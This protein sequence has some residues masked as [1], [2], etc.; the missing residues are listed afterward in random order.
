METINYDLS[1]DE[2]FKDLFDMSIHQG[3]IIS[4]DY[5]NN[6]AEVDIDDIGVKSEVPIFYHCQD[7]TTTAGATAFGVD[8]RVWVINQEGGCE[9]NVSNLKIVGFVDGLKECLQTFILVECGAYVFLFGETNYFYP[10]SLPEISYPCL[11][12][13]IQEFLDTQDLAVTTSLYTGVSAGEHPSFDPTLDC[14]YGD[15]PYDPDPDPSYLSANTGCGDFWNTIECLGHPAYHRI[16]PARRD[17]PA[18]GLAY[19]FPGSWNYSL[20]DFPGQ[21][22][23]YRTRVDYERSETLPSPP[24]PEFAS[25]IHERRTWYTPI[26]TMGYQVGGYGLGYFIEW[27]GADRW[28]GYTASDSPGDLAGPRTQNFYIRTARSMIQIYYVQWIQTKHVGHL[29]YKFRR[30]WHILAALN[31]YEDASIIDP[32]NQTESDAFKAAINNLRDY[33]MTINELANDGAWSPGEYDS[34]NVLTEAPEYDTTPDMVFTMY[35]Y[36]EE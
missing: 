36:V 25:N 11:K 1:D 27:S 14:N 3:T 22:S 10:P 4:V 9:P 26:G 34:D 33:Y 2:E 32:R 31:I 23:C 28:D 17:A 21:T 35:D 13:E 8:D 16:Q 15:P 6:K 30:N 7:N 24:A 5:T 29:I 12:T 19:N 18:F 20:S